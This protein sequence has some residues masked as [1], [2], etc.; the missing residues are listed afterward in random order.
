MNGA[1]ASAGA[2]LAVVV[3]AGPASAAPARRQGP[4]MSSRLPSAGTRPSSTVTEIPVE[5]RGRAVEYTGAEGRA[6][7]TGG[8]TV[9]RG[10]A[11]LVSDELETIQGADEAIARGNVH[12]TD[13]ERQLDLVCQE[14]HYTHGMSRLVATG[15]CVLVAGEG[16][17]R[18]VVGADA[19][20]VLVETR[21]AL[22]HGSVR[23]VQGDD[24]ATCASAH[25]YGAENRVVLTG[26]PV[27]RRP[28][29]EFECDEMTAYFREGRSVL[30]G[31]VK[32]RIAPE[33]FEGL[34]REA[35]PQ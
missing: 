32:G 12:F 34:R 4:S 19:M 20:E 28:P 33:K 29:H 10:S 23:I 17:E 21:E 26:R 25:L 1:L 6:K 31:S 27:L 18:T 13:A 35:V 3:L 22:G 5:I 11:T 9:T 7:F 2:L 15:N 30:T 16:D 8:V 24:E 14:A